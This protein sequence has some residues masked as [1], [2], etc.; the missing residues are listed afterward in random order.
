MVIIPFG[1]G[2]ERVTA[3]VQCNDLRNFPNTDIIHVKNLSM[4]GSA[5]QNK[6]LINRPISL[7]LILFLVYNSSPKTILRLEFYR[8][9]QWVPKTCLVVYG[10]GGALL[11]Q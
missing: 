6:N 8:G 7:A 1:S 11:Q 3:F 2:P 5:L 9:L 4:Q 10:I